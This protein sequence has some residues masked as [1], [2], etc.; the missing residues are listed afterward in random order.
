LFAE[1]GPEQLYQVQK[2]L[3]K[4]A[5]ENKKISYFFLNDTDLHKLRESGFISRRKG[6]KLNAPNNEIFNNF[7]IRP[8]GTDYHTTIMDAY[9]QYLKDYKFIHFLETN[10]FVDDSGQSKTFVEYHFIVKE[11]IESIGRPKPISV[12]IQNEEEPQMPNGE[13]PQRQNGE[14]QIEINNEEEP[15]IPNGKEPQIYIPEY[16]QTFT[17]QAAQQ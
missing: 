5:V 13:E 10:K 6:Y 12:P 8:L 7:T 3:L 4:Q 14:E 15:Q 11:Y 17:Q 16:N 2:D 1:A 9:I